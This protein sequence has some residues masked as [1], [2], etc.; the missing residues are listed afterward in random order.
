M[1]LVM[2][3]GLCFV[4]SEE[5]RLPLPKPTAQILQRHSIELKNRGKEDFPRFLY[6]LHR[7]RPKVVI[8]LGTWYT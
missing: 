2:V 8:R 1:S 6:S 4:P 5:E 3:A 7:T